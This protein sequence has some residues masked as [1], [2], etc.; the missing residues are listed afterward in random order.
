MDLHLENFHS[1]LNN[2]QFIEDDVPNLKMTIMNDDNENENEN[3]NE[4]K[5]FVYE[6]SIIETSY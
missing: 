2:N 4:N 3:E 5:N 1:D 6:E